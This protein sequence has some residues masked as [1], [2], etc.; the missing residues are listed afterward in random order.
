MK[1]II[2]FSVTT[3]IGI[4]IILFS[5][6]R[7]E[8]IPIL[9][10]TPKQNSPFVKAV[11]RGSF[12]ETISKD[13]IALVKFYAPWCGFCKR[14][15]PIFAE[16]AEQLKDEEIS[17]VEVDATREFILS[18]KYQINS[19]PKIKVFKNG[20][21][22]EDYNGARTV[23]SITAYAKRLL[24]Q[25][26]PEINSLEKLQ[27]FI[28]D[29]DKVVIFFLN[30]KT[31]NNPNLDFEKI[32]EKFPEIQFALVKNEKI[33]E[34]YN[35]SQFPTMI[36]FRNE[37]LEQFNFHDLKTEAFLE[38]LENHQKLQFQQIETR[39]GFYFQED[40][41]FFILFLNEETKKNSLPILKELSKSSPNISFFWIDNKTLPIESIRFGVYSFPCAVF[42]S[43]KNELNH[44]KFFRLDLENEPISVTKLNEFI[45][46]CL[47]GKLLF[48]QKSEPIPSTQGTVLTVVFKNWKEIIENPEKITVLYVYSQFSKEDLKFLSKFENFAEEFK[49]FQNIQF[50]K[51]EG[52]A[53]TLGILDQ[54]LDYPNILIFNE[55]DKTI[56]KKFEEKWDQ[57]K[58]IKF[59]QEFFVLNPPLKTTNPKEL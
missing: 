32:T 2:F 51:I 45:S 54:N 7:I 47:G 27:S 19:Y 49:H 30:E 14:L 35:V 34:K 4:F 59:L 46:D 12:Y 42:I 16:A 20:E 26:F 56:Y 53:N 36:F 58:A 40:K 31:E 41:S 57:E 8:Y 48:A 50:A 3:F 55:E 10:G 37:D 15:D 24:I 1:L 11:N 5:I 6:S 43:S 23:R 13:K 18:R 22:Y 21:F 25:K 52:F 17:F 28:N 38:F 33:A 9:S 29:F 44:K 39:L